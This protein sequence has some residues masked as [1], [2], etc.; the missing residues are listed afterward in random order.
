M[1][2]MFTHPTGAGPVV[3]PKEYCHNIAIYVFT[4]HLNLKQF[5]GFQESGR[6][7]RKLLLRDHRAFFW[8]NETIRELERGGSDAI[9][10][11]YEIPQG[12]K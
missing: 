8:G 6:K 11:V 10:W 9:S 3:F 7:N 12:K 5:W 1:H 2:R 4:S